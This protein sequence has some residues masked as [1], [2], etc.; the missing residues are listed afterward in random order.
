MKIKCYN[1]E[2]NKEFDYETRLSVCCSDECLDKY[3]PK[4]RVPDS[5]NRKYR[6]ADGSLQNRIKQ[7]RAEASTDSKAYNDFIKEF[8]KPLI[9][10]EK[11]ES[12]L[13]EPGK[14][15]QDKAHIPVK[16]NS[17]MRSQYRR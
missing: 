4:N 7:L 8:N 3:W 11:Q 13:L 9:Q 5:R 15:N 6:F 1:I 16:T 17:Y 10:D 2:C 14:R 12:R